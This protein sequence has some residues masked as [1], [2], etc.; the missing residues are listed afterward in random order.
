M[1]LNPCRCLLT[2]KLRTPCYEKGES[3]VY[4]KTVNSWP[5]SGSGRL[6]Q[7]RFMLKSTRCTVTCTKVCW[8]GSES[9][10]GG[11]N[12]F[13]TNNPF[14]AKGAGVPPNG[15]KTLLW[16]KPRNG[17]RSLTSSYRAYPVAI[18]P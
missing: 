2:V 6:R 7:T 11:V 12:C 15:K 10:D 1:F 3:R 9:A 5:T 13:A 17:R 4:S 8:I 16:S 14:W 18:V